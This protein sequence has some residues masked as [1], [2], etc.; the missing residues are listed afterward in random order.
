M[1]HRQL[2]LR[3]LCLGKGLIMRNPFARRPNAAVVSEQ[4][5]S[6]GR[7]LDR[8]QRRA[9]LAGRDEEVSTIEGLLVRHDP[10]GINF[11]DNT[12]EYRPE[13]ETITLRRP[14]GRTLPGI[15]ALVHQEFIRW[16][17]DTAGPESTYEEVARELHCFWNGEHV[18]SQTTLGGAGQLLRIWSSGRGDR[19]LRRDEIGVEWCGQAGHPSSYALLVG[20]RFDAASAIA[21]RY[22]DPQQFHGS[23]AGICDQV[24]WALPAEY[25]DAVLQAIGPGIEITVAA[26]GVIGSSNR[27]FERVGRMLRELLT[28]HHDDDDLWSLWHAASTA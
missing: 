20:R 8:T 19:L 21:L 3:A 1:D 7:Q 2:D 11:E 26:H 18:P 6:D 22:E 16:F 17:D 14:E 10:I 15:R 12:D 5:D 23:L 24:Y 25:H 4:L 13:A 28:S 9:L 27:A